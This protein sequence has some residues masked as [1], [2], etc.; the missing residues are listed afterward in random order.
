MNE[1]PSSADTSA[2]RVPIAHRGSTAA[3][4]GMP[5]WVKVGAIV[6]VVLVLL[7]VLGM[8]AAGG[9]HGP[10]RHIPSASSV[11]TLILLGF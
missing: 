3:Y 9:E 8:V 10:T 7:V 2:E 6:T 5:R 4:P 11:N 1:S